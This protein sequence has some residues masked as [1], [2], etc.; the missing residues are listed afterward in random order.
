M[1][2]SHPRDRDEHLAA[3][4]AVGQLYRQ[5]CKHLGGRPKDQ[6]KMALLEQALAWH[7]VATLERRRAEIGDLTPRAEREASRSAAHACSRRDKCIEKLLAEPSA[8][9]AEELYRES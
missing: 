5:M 1:P 8:D 4:R 6:V 3:N 9:P 2:R 7:R